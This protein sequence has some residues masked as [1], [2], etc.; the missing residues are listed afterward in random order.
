MMFIWASEYHKNFVSKLYQSYHYLK[1]ERVELPTTPIIASQKVS[2][3]TQEI[4][5]ILSLLQAFCCT[6]TMEVQ[7][8]K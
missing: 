7:E 3:T 2:C 8:G 1:D 5:I 6:D 4:L